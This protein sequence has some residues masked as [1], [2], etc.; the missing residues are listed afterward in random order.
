MIKNLPNYLA[1]AGQDSA[2]IGNNLSGVVSPDVL[3]QLQQQAAERGISMGS[4]LS[5]NSNS[6]YLRALGLTSMQLQQLGHTQL[7]EAIQRTPIQQTQNQSA[8]KDWSAEQAIYNSAPVPS[9][10]AKQAI[11]NAQNAYGYGKNSAYGA[12]GGSNWYAGRPQAQYGSGLF[13]M[14]SNGYKVVYR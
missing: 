4:P 3:Y 6:A 9:A 8:T 2:N 7:N 11:L 1:L 5:D 14:F 12:G 10:A 13:P